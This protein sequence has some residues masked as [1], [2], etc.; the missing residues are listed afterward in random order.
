MSNRTVPAAAEGLPASTPTPTAPDA[1]TGAARILARIAE[2]NAKQL[3]PSALTS[4][5]VAEQIR[6]QLGDNLSSSPAAPLI[7]PNGT[8][9]CLAFVIAW[10]AAGNALEGL[11]ADE[12]DKAWER[13]VKPFDIA[14]NEGRIPTPTTPEGAAFALNKALSFGDLD[15]QDTGLVRAALA[16]LETCPSPHPSPAMVA[17]IETHRAALSAYTAIADALELYGQDAGHS[18]DT[19]SALGVASDATGKVAHKAWVDVLMLTPANDADVRAKLEY[20]N[21]SERLLNLLDNDDAFSLVVGLS[22]R[23]AR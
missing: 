8:D 23:A 19:A 14:A 5:D 6:R 9:P 4:E 17:A 2:G 7:T 20:I 22:M 3:G 1:K 21:G 18:A 12:A 10:N 15:E 11:S 16:Y 13:T